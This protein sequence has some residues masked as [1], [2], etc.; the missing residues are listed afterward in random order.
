[1]I[2]RGAQRNL[3]AISNLLYQTAAVTAG[4]SL[5]YF[6][7]GGAAAG[8]VWFGGAV[9]LSNAMLLVW[10]IR[11]AANRPAQEPRRELA[12]LVR[13]SMERFFMVSLL[14]AVGLGWM[15]LMPLPLLAGFALGQLAL[16]VSTIISG[17]EK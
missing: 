3:Y 9:A 16:V 17:I 7:G 6:L 15:K 14:M 5:A 10:R 4:A 12:G 8:A 13:S 11:S 1:M 2:F